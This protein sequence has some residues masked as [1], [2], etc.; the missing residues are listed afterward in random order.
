MKHAFSRAERLNRIQ[1]LLSTVSPGITRSDLARRLGVSRAT[2]SRDIADLSVECPIIEDERS[3]RLTLSRLSLLSNLYLTV[4]EIQALHLACRLLG[5]KVRF[6]YPS[7]SSSLRKLGNALNNYAEP[8]ASAIIATAEIFE[9]HQL[10][11]RSHYAETVKIITEG[12][13]KGLSVRFERFSR[14]EGCWKI[15][16][17]G[18][19]CIEPYAEGN[20]LYLVGIE[21]PSS[22][23]R[24]IKFEL[25]RNIELTD[26]PYLIPKSFR[27]DDYFEKSWGIWTTEGE[28]QQVVIDFS[29][30]VRDRVLQTEWHKS[31]ATEFLS[32]GGLR[33][34]A[35]I[36]EPLEMMPWIRGWGS[37]AVV[38]RPLWLREK[39]KED[40]GICCEHYGLQVL[41]ESGKDC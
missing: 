26:I 23:T 25:I 40:F 41:S 36:A 22:E 12:I 35:M 11:N 2:I 32:D 5:R 34:S 8:M 21:K 13:M 24:T 20:S 29:E 28:T 1:L 16:V 30:K 15:C 9:S 31:E 18:S 14:R 7:A 3:G 37:D 27:A 39:I 17:F 6:N 33:W 19:Y 38:L 4:E 10:K